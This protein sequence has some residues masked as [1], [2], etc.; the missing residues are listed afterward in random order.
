MDN[1][2]EACMQ[3]MDFEAIFYD[4][5]GGTLPAKEYLDNLDAKMFAKIIRNIEVVESGGTTVREPYSKHLQD[6]I[7][8]IRA[9][10]SSNLARVLYFFFDGRRI[11]LTHGFT[12]KTQK[13][14]SAEIALAKKYRAEYLNRE[15]NK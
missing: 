13:T 10:V 12:K 7:F 9:Q 1:S 2:W 8:E 6:G 4:K 14:P 3:S 11:I 5:P 15:E